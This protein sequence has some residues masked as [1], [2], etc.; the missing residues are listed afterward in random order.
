M[1]DGIRWFKCKLK[2][3]KN[4]LGVGMTF[5]L[6][7]HCGEVAMTFS[8]GLVHINDCGVKPDALTLGIVAQLVCKVNT[9]KYGGYVHFS[10]PYDF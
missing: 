9:G 2:P 5:T 10:C 4:G 7:K 3:P 6:V 1:P 8:K